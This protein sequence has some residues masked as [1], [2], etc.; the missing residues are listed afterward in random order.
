M[1]SWRWFGRRIALGT[2][3]IW[4]C[5]RRQ[6]HLPGL[7]HSCQ[8]VPGC[9]RTDV[10]TCPRA[11]SGHQGTRPRSPRCDTRESHTRWASS[12]PYCCSATIRRILPCVG[13]WV[14]T[15]Q[16]RECTIKHNAGHRGGMI[17]LP[18]DAGLPQA[19]TLRVFS[20]LM[21]TGN[22]GRHGH[23]SSPLATL[24]ATECCARGRRRRAERSSAAQNLAASAH[25]CSVAVC[26]NGSSVTG[27]ILSR[28]HH[29]DNA[30][31]RLHCG[32]QV[33]WRWSL[34]SRGPWLDE[35]FAVDV[36]CSTRLD[37]TG[38]HDRFLTART[39]FDCSMTR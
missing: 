3:P 5:S 11:S 9:C 15:P 13:V 24:F 18:H 31:V 14:A 39:C 4:A 28:L 7:C 37:A 10:G 35:H 26:Q 38:R 27:R 19:R 12:V 6:R 34:L 16:C 1:R 20:R 32:E 29:K 25:C 2:R 21:G 33:T 17:N 30:G 23:H 36:A 22:P 8:Y